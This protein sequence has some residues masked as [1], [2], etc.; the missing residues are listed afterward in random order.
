MKRIKKWWRDRNRTSW[1]Y[2]HQ[3]RHDLNGDNQSFLMELDNRWHYKCAHCGAFSVFS[4]DYP[5]P[6]RV[7]GTVEKQ[8]Q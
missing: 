5:V 2:C 8:Q 3:C 7:A 1:L 4:L 6:V